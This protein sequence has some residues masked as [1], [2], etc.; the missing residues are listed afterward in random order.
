MV[1]LIFDTVLKKHRPKSIRPTLTR[2]FCIK[3]KQFT[4]LIF[5]LRTPI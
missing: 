1:K 3:H 4:N 5:A 2:L